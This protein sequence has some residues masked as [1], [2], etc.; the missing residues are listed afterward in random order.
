MKFWCFSLMLVKAFLR[1]DE[2]FPQAFGVFV[3]M[4][5]QGSP[6]IRRVLRAILVVFFVNPMIAQLGVHKEH[7]ENS[8]KD[9]TASINIHHLALYIILLPALPRISNERSISIKW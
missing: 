4:A 6:N 2:T 9:T 8:T 1:G 3:S 7:E 5:T